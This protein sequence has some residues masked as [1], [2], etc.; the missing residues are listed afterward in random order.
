M[1]LYQTYEQKPGRTAE[2]RPWLKDSQGRFKNPYITYVM[3]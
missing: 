2:N 3:Q 1:F